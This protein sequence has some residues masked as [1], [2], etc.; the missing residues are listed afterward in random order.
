[1][2]K[3]MKRYE[4]GGLT[5]AE[6]D[7]EDRD[8][9]AR[10]AI[11]E[12]NARQAEKSAAASA[13]PKKRVT[14]RQSKPAPKGD[15]REN[16]RD[17]DMQGADTGYDATEKARMARQTGSRH[18]SGRNIPLAE[19]QIV[20]RKKKGAVEDLIDIFKN[21]PKTGM[22]KGGKVTSTASKRAD[23]CAQRGKTRGKMV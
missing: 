9:T 12:L 10:K 14:A 22:K 23:G 18:Y 5:F 1:M 7:Q 6:M 4:D 15:T 16:L 19:P 8:E 3:R 17:L 11:A 21:A 2:K 20:E 13:E